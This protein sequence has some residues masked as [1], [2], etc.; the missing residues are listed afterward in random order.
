MDLQDEGSKKRMKLIAA[1]LALVLFALGGYLLYRL[2]SGSEKGC[3]LTK[4]TMKTEDRATF[5]WENGKVATAYL[6]KENG[7]CIYRGSLQ[8]EPESKAL[9]S[10]CAGEDRNIAIQSKE[11]CDTDATLLQN[12]TFHFPDLF[13]DSLA[14]D[15]YDYEEPE[16]HR[17]RRSLSA[18]DDYQYKEYDE[19]YLENDDFDK[20]YPVPRDAEFAEPIFPKVLHLPVHVHLSPSW[21]QYIGKNSSQTARTEAKKVLARANDHLQHRSM[22]PTQINIA[23]HHLSFFDAAESDEL[24]PSGED[25]ER[26]AC[27]S[28]SQPC[29]VNLPKEERVAVVYLTANPH[30]RLSGIAMPRSICG[31]KM[32]ASI[33]RMITTGYG[34]LP[35]TKTAMTLAHEI[36]HNFGIYH[37]FENHDN[38][39][40]IARTKKCG[41]PKWTGGDQPDGGNNLIMN[42]GSPRKAEWSD[43]SSEDFSNYFSRV[44]QETS[45]C[46][47]EDLTCDGVKCLNE[48]HCRPSGPQPICV[49]ASGW[50]GERCERCARCE[51][52]ED[53][54][55]ASME[56][57]SAILALFVLQMCLFRF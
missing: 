11:H 49:C 56:R 46:L 50:Y 32:A 41:P 28:K 14:H 31:N 5:E 16:E 4:F 42:Y 20:A 38:K 51:Q 12:G 13:D 48:G 57:L 36:A 17:E 22:K 3:I 54:G 30:S 44:A 47:K 27:E 18:T 39:P 55:S 8:G 53:P 7:E 1:I 33:T 24:H 21:I 45:F 35:I 2:T 15:S 19:E 6:T 40:A 23:Y 29:F 9:V 26:L 52:K 25:L 43:C 10:G 37:D 34:T